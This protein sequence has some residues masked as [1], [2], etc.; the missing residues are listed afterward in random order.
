MQCTNCGLPLSPTNT[1]ACPRCHTSLTSGPKPVVGKRQSPQQYNN[2]AWG[3]RGGQ[4]EW[5]NSSYQNQN[6]LPFPPVATPVQTPFPQPGQMWQVT[7]APA[8]PPTPIPAPLG[9]I[10]VGAIDRAPTP[11]MMPT[12]TVGAMDS[13]P[14]P[15]LRP[16]ARRAS[17]LGFYVAGLCVI[18]GGLILIFVYI[19]ALGLPSSS[20]TSAFT[21]SPSATKNPALTPT[22][23]TPAP[24]AVLSPTTGLFPGQPYINTP[25]MASMVNINTAQPLQTTTTFKV[26]QKIYVTFAINP[27][28][29]NGA[30]CLFWYLNNRIVTQFPFAVTSSARAGYSYAIYGGT[31]AAYV[32]I[33]WASTITCSD[34][35]LAQ[36][37]T[38]TVTK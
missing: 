33:Y 27:N 30:V 34:K 21:A 18:A 8:P 38:F 25:Q 7:P 36:H 6:Q 26:N 23:T 2:Q 15:A 14:T 20:T 3:G 9:A 28:G 5:T 1:S 31:G 32:E 24:T 16:Q 29:K 17:N 11:Y 4:A 22:A 13:S 10:P 35:I 37:V 19:L 12:Q